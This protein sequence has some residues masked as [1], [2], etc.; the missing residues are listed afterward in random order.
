M[1]Y[2]VTYKY[3]NLS[4][5]EVEPIVAAQTELNYRKSVFLVNCC[6]WWQLQ[7]FTR[8]TLLR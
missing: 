8:K 6:S 1:A 3:I 5:D 4:Q 2:H 7:Q